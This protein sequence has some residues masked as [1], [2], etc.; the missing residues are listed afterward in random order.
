MGRFYPGR[1]CITCPL[2]PPPSTLVPLRC[3]IVNDH[4]TVCT[5]TKSLCNTPETNKLYLSEKQ[6]LKIRS[7]TGEAGFKTTSKHFQAC[8]LHIRICHIF[9]VYFNNYLK[10]GN[11]WSEVAQSCPT[12]CDPMN[13]SLPGSSIHGIFQAR[14]PEWFAISFSRKEQ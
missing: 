11:K 8:H 4:F 12:L 13:S 3:M 1:K 14:V 5:N 2:L 10:K 6:K 9:W 7:D